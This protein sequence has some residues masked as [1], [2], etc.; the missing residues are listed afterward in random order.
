MAGPN[1][2][3]PTGG[4]AKYS[5]ALSVDDFLTASQFTCYSRQALEKIAGKIIR[6]AEIEGLEG[7]VRSILSRFQKEDML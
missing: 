2:T 5:S 4:S 7:H 1:H 6:F 3:L